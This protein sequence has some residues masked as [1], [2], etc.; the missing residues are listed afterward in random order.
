MQAKVTA[1]IITQAKADAAVAL[2]DGPTATGILPSPNLRAAL[3][4]LYGT[5]AEPAIDSF[6]GKS[7][8]TGKPWST[9]DFNAAISASAPSAET[10]ISVNGR[11]YTY[12]RP[13][14]AGEPFQVLSSI[15][16]REVMRQDA[17]ASDP[18]T[19]TL[20]DSQDESIVVSSVE[21]I[22]YVQQLLI[23]PTVAANH[24]TLVNRGNDRLLALLNSGDTLFP[25]GG[26]LQ[27]PA[28]NSPGNVFVGGKNDPGNYNDTTT[29]KSFENWI[30]REYAFRGFA[31]GGT[32]S[33]PTS[34]TILKNIVGTTGNFSLFGTE[35]EGF[36]DNRN[37]ILT[38]V[39][40]IKMAEALKLTF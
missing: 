28:L 10:K 25:Y 11:L 5:V 26:I 18:A 7:N 2:F 15:L 24:T 12:F 36:L 19:G 34:V 40:Y 23:D 9:I 14:F 30:R 38:D 31:A 21:T 8:V 27:A 37:A 4:S 32:S 3:A 6:I 16:A 35:V 17:T 20:P 13:T 39:A 1:G 22:V 33:N 29:V